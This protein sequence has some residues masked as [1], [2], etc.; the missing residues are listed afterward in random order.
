MKKMGD[1]MKKFSCLVVLCL[2]AVLL[3]SGCMGSGLKTGSVYENK[4][5]NMSITIKS[6]EELTFSYKGY[7]VDIP[8]T[9]NDDGTL[10][11]SCNLGVAS[12]DCS[13]VPNKQADSLVCTVRGNVKSL[14]DS[15][16]S[17]V[18]SKV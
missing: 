13:V 3:L 9:S 18:L 8:Y 4:T 17:V 15:E 14:G 16:V 2:C 10:S 7:K 12:V 6:D 1:L 11:F 5:N